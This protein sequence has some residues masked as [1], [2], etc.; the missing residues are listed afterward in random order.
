MMKRKLFCSLIGEYIL[1]DN[2]EY[3][4]NIATTLKHSSNIAMLLHYWTLL[5]HMNYFVREDIL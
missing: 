3:F 5:S 1:P 2:M 4:N